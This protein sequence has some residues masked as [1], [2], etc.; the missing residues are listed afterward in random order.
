ML[1]FKPAAHTAMYYM[2][3][4]RLYGQLTV[5]TS[6]MQWGCARSCVMGHFKEHHMR[7]VCCQLK[8]HACYLLAA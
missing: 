3:P 1:Y 6:A 4:G 8:G 2:L 7:S 5:G